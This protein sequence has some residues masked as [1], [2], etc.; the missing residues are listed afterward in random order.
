MTAIALT[1]RQR[2]RSLAAIISAGFGAGMSMASLLPLISLLLERRGFEAGLIGLNAAMFPISVLCFG[3]VAPLVVRRLGAV[4]TLLLSAVGFMLLTPLYYLT[5]PWSWYGWRFIAGFLGAIGWMTSEAWI[6]MVARPETRGRIMAVYSTVIAAGMMIGPF[7]ISAIG[8]EGFWPFLFIMG[9]T[10]LTALP[11]FFARGLSPDFSRQQPLQPWAAFKHAPTV[12]VGAIAGGAVDMAVM[13]LLPVW[14]V[15]E[16]FSQA[17]AAR[18]ISVFAAGSL[19]MQWPIGWLAD[20]WSR[21]GMLL[22]CSAVTGAGALLL[23]VLAG[24]P[25]LLWPAIFIWGGVVFGVYTAALALMGDRFPGN[26]LAGANALFIMA[27]QVGSLGGPPVA[28]ISMD[29]FGAMGL[30]VMIAVVSA[31][32]LLFGLIRR[33]MMR[34]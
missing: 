28:G 23:P 32:Y 13:A 3:A 34:G 5:D 30:P 4:R 10:S 18:L 7:I 6:N 26:E 33:A 27:Y 2:R 8:I 14:G 16:G 12:L 11:L 15:A 17:D 1:E 21:R 20:H 24:E 29:R 9:A 19:L 31:A 25:L 22:G